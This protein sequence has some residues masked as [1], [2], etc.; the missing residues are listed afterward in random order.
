MEAPSID[1]RVD[2][3]AFRRQIELWRSANRGSGESGRIGQCLAAYYAGLYG[4]LSDAFLERCAERPEDFGKAGDMATILNLRGVKNSESAGDYGD[5]IEVGRFDVVP[6]GH[7]AKFVLDAGGFERLAAAEPGGLFLGVYDCMGDAESG[8]GDKGRGWSSHYF[9]WHFSTDGVLS[10]F[11]P[12]TGKLSSGSGEIRAWFAAERATA[13]HVLIVREMPRYN[14]SWAEFAARAAGNAG[15]APVAAREDAPRPKEKAKNDPDAADTAAKPANTRSTAEPAPSAKQPKGM[16]DASE[17]L[18]RQPLRASTGAQIPFGRSPDSLARKPR[19]FYRRAVRNFSGRRAEVAWVDRDLISDALK[20]GSAA[21]VVLC[22]PGMRNSG[23]ALELQEQSS[24]AATRFRRAE[25][26]HG[27]TFAFVYLRS[28]AAAE[29]SRKDPV[30]ARDRFIMEREGGS[31]QIVASS[32]DE[33]KRRLFLYSDANGYMLG[34]IYP[35]V[36]RLT[37]CGRI[38]GRYRPRRDHLGAPD[39]NSLPAGG[40]RPK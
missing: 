14:A 25:D 38:R 2:A 11:D 1:G 28:H 26:Q 36:D 10:V 35:P 34:L 22:A 8:G 7:R 39:C 16:D 31:E 24:S 18:E 32:L 12:Q 20:P 21:K 33:L 23:R 4:E 40:D 6:G 27:A 3:A 9:L 19:V 37:A 29:G 15:R 5:W 17:R 13:C 30:P